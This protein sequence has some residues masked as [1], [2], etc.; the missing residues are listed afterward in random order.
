METL[1]DSVV[2]LLLHSAPSVNGKLT[3]LDMPQYT[4]LSNFLQSCFSNRKLESCSIQVLKPQCLDD[5]SLNLF[6]HFT[7]VWSLYK[8]R[9][10]RR[11]RKHAH[12]IQHKQRYRIFKNKEFNACCIQMQDK[13]EFSTWL[14]DTMYKS[15]VAQAQTIWKVQVL[16]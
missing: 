14:Y 15:Y 7:T 10:W 6:F 5:R 9:N 1:Y 4:N 8:C 2:K 11:V 3:S 13:Q 12:P 16:S